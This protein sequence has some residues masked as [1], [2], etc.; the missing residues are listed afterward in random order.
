M[1]VIPFDRR[2]RRPGG[3]E[4]W[5]Y[6]YNCTLLVKKRGGKMVLYG[7]NYDHSPHPHSVRLGVLDNCLAFAHFLDL[8]RDNLRDDPD[9]RPTPPRKRRTVS[10]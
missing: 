5:P 1:S 9:W 8:F 10:Q 3:Q 2:R 7:V 6:F 4:P